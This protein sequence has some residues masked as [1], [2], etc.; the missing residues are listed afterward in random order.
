MNKLTDSQKKTLDKLTNEWQSS[1]S[2]KAGRMTLDSLVHKGLAERRYPVGSIA[3]PATT[4]YRLAQ[5][6]PANPG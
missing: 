4:E 1:Y 5:R 2:I 3:F 6:E